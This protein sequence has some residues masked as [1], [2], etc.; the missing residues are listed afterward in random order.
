MASTQYHLH[1]IRCGCVRVRVRYMGTNN[2]L[3][4]TQHQMTNFHALDN[5]LSG[6][7]KGK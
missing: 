4:T 3:E 6:T 1:S 2:L 5:I 7:E